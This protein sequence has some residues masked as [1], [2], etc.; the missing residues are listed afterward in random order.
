[1]RPCDLATLWTIEMWTFVDLLVLFTEIYLKTNK[2]IQ[3]LKYT[4]TNHVN[5]NKDVYHNFF[6]GMGNIWK[7]TKKKMLLPTTCQEW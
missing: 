6:F 4:N 5:T 7:Q 2:N 3:F 1:M